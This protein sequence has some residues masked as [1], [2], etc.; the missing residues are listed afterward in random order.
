MHNNLDKQ[1]DDTYIQ[2]RREGV[3][4]PLFRLPSLLQDPSSPFSTECVKGQ[5]EW[6]TVI[7]AQYTVAIL[8]IFVWKGLLNS[9]V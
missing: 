3:Q 7:M 2:G 1:T 9:V 8:M 5:N 4:E 6:V